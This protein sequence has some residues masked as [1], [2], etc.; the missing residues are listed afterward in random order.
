MWE[1]DL[2][3]MLTYARQNK[4]VHFL[5]VVV[6]WFT[7]K[8]FVAPYKHK[9]QHD[10]LD[11]FRDI[12]E[13]QTTSRPR[14]IYSDNGK[15]FLN[16]AVSHY[17]QSINVE[18]STTNDTSVKG[19]IVEHANQTLKKTQSR[20]APRWKVPRPTAEHRHR[21]EQQRACH[22][23]TRT[24]RHQFRQRQHG[25]H[26]HQKNILK[27]TTTNGSAFQNVQNKTNRI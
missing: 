25:V 13:G 19:A 10:V 23:A 22:H 8:L 1:A 12:F 16:T 24:Q 27:L 7:K 3:D 11:A 5:L 2:L 4:G 15:E 6:N 20:P 21:T 9:N 14:V 17:L 18:H 26:Q